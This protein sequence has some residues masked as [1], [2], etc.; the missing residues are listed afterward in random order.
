MLRN[1]LK[2]TWRTLKRRPGYTAINVGGL[3]VG[4]A[5]C[6]LIALFV[7]HE[8]SYDDFHAKADRTYRVAESSEGGKWTEGNLLQSARLAPAL[9]RDVPGVAE[10]VR[11]SFRWGRDVKVERGDATFYEDPFLLAD[12][13]F[14]GVFEGFDLVRGS[15]ETA[16]AEPFSVVL[17]ERT[18][19]KYFGDQNPMGR[20]I[21]ARGYGEM[22]ELTVTGVA[23]NPPPNTHL[24]FDLLASFNTLPSTMPSPEHLDSWGYRAHYTYVVL[25]E[26]ARP[27]GFAQRMAAFGETHEDA[28]N[29]DSDF[30]LQP[31]TGIHLRSDFERELAPGSDMRYVYLF[32]GLAL[33]VL[34]VAC[35]NYMNLATARSAH[36]AKEVG[37]RK[38]VGAHRGQLA[39]QFL[40]ESALLCAGA[41]VLALVLARAALPLFNQLTGEALSFGYAAQGGLLLGFL[42]VGVLVSLM[43]GSYPALVLSRIEPVPVLR[44]FFRG[45]KRSAALR[46]GL[47]VV[48][49]AVSVALIAATLIA[50]RQLRH[51]Q[52]KTLG[53][54]TEHVAAIHARDA[55]NGRETE[56]RGNYHVFKQELLQRA[57]ISGVTATSQ[58]L[59]AS[60]GTFGGSSLV[61][62]GHEPQKRF[63]E[64]DLVINRTTVDPDFTDVMDIPVLEGRDLSARFQSEEHTPALINEAAAQALGWDAPV[65]KTFTCCY[66]PMPRVV[67]VVEDFHYQSLQQKIE[68][69]VLVKRWADQDAYYGPSRVLVRMP[70]G[71]PAGTLE[72]LREQWAEVSDT[73][74]AYSFVDEQFDAAYRAETRTAGVFGT[75]AALAVLLA[76]LG[77]FGLAAYAAERRRKE[78]GV[79]KAMGASTRN[80]V[81]LL[82]RDF[83]K[84]VLVA[85]VLAVPVAWWAMR[86]WLGG[87]AYRIELSLWTFLAAGA[88]ALVVA[89]AATGTQALRAARTNPAQALRDE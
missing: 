31:I 56:Q 6:F 25:D 38:V 80:I 29:D 85:V 72:V 28:G 18:A 22:R 42:G 66:K 21:R 64:K 27:A 7:R 81:T 89:L 36:R 10:A 63:D 52:T 67:G 23:G 35:V 82:S 70:P 37:V 2:T 15:P 39:R 55:L 86:Q 68:P 53:L 12:S 9:E 19:R 5:A 59:P 30:V 69:L 51:M 16:L 45:G 75:F 13:S 88:L 60:E 78:I 41:L 3:A 54:D 1:Y 14:F 33:L 34:G 50:A 87:F 20:T 17:T 43:A 24:S 47:V 76:C 8:L 73:P 44:G 26:G 46:K 58:S 74:F 4:L 32:S 65:G 57:G 83:V 40:G 71:D 77:L 79:R 49:F 11:V 62:E 61:P 84:L 48:Q